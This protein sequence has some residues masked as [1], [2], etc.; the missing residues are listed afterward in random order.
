MTSRTTSEALPVIDTSTGNR[1]DYLIAGIGL[2]VMAVLAP[3]GFLVALP[4]GNLGTAATVAF[5]VGVLDVVV[6]IAL[7]RVLMDG[8]RRLSIIGA[9]LRIA[10]AVALLGAAVVLLATADAAQFEGIWDRAL[11]LF[12]VHLVVVGVSILRSAAP[13]WIGILVII[14]GAGYLVD[15]SGVIAG[16][17]LGFEVSQIAFIGEVALMIW[18][19]WRGVRPGNR[20]GRA[21]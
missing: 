13:N 17:P 9:A 18:L 20:R 4:Q 8:G 11:F 19:L 14:A 10:Y 15:A 2:L 7:A 3:I 16:Q 12:G 1:T 5:V 21:G 6:A